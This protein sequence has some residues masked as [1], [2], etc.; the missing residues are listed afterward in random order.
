MYPTLSILNLL[1]FR[2]CK[3]QK[4]R[5]AVVERDIPPGVLPPGVSASLADM[6]VSG[7]KRRVPDDKIYNQVW[8]LQC[9]HTMLM[10]QS[11]GILSRISRVNTNYFG[12]GRK[13]HQRNV[14]FE[15][16]LELAFIT[17]MPF[18]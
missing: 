16:D 10:S 4:S 1:M 5:V 9:I 2:W 6:K 15:I 12:R 17:V 8:S 11:N 14:M 3:G 13:Y 18:H 7:G